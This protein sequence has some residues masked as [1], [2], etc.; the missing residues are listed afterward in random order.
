MLP[1]RYFAS[2]LTK[3]N[4]SDR[5]HSNTLSHENCVLSKRRLIRDRSCAGAAWQAIVAD[6]ALATGQGARQ[7]MGVRL[8]TSPRRDPGDRQQPAIP[9]RPLSQC[10]HSVRYLD[11]EGEGDIVL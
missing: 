1:Q 10:R 6:V 11:G 2:R 5:E 4:W 9:F 8:K 3:Q 7:S